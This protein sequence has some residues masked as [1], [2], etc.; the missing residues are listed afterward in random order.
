VKKEMVRALKNPDNWKPNV[1]KIAEE[2][3]LD[4]SSVSKYLQRH[5]KEIDVSIRIKGPEELAEETTQ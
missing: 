4:N 1:T 2:V 3:E 5:K